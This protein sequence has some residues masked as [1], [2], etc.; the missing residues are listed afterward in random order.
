MNNHHSYN[1][2]F[3]ALLHQY[4]ICCFIEHCR[5]S[6]ERK[7]AAA[8]FCSK[9]Y[10]QLRGLLIQAI[11][12][13]WRNSGAGGLICPS[14]QGRKNFF[15]C[16]GELLQKRA[17]QEF[18]KFVPGFLFSLFE[19]AAV[20]FIFFSL[21][22]YNLFICIYKCIFINIYLFAYNTYSFMHLYV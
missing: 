1:C 7:T 22:Q 14:T 3:P 13:K 2:C 8:K 20:G 18:E 15:L 21:N 12:I 17:L 9:K 19:A 16:L 11:G 6:P 4:L 5:R 10:F